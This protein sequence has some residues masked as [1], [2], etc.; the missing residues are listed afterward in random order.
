MSQTDPYTY[1]AFVSYTD[2]DSD[3]VENELLPRITGAG[4]AICTGQQD[5][6]VGAPRI[7]EVE[8]LIVTSRKT[9]LVLT[10]AYLDDEWAEYGSAMVQSLDPASR[11]LRLIPLL[12]EPCELPLRIRHLIPVD[13]SEDE[14]MDLNWQRLLKALDA[15]SYPS[16]P[17]P[18]SSRGTTEISRRDLRTRLME[19]CSLADLGDLCFELD[20]DRENYAR[21]KQDFARE[22]LVDLERKGRTDDLIAV[23]REQMSWV[24]DDN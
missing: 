22:L 24:L 3:W 13:F 6:R 16:P 9:I 15:A 10:P 1:D 2:A 7:S 23:L 17:P 11:D 19:H 18:P 20:L 5:F 4:L 12:K 21:N 8:R 14:D